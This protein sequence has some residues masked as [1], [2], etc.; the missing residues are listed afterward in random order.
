LPRGPRM[1]SYISS[2][3]S[4]LAA[5][6][7]IALVEVSYATV[8]TSSAV[9]RSSF[10][11]WN[12]N[13]IELFQKAL[14]YE[15]LQNA[16]Q[17]KPAVIQIGD[18]SGLHAIV[19]RIVDQYLEGLKYENV[20]C[21]ANT[22]FD[23]YYTIAEFMLRNSPSIKAVVLYLSWQNAPRDPARMPTDMIG[24]GD[25]MRNALGWLAPFVSPPT[26]SARAEIL[27]SVYTLSHVIEQPSLL[28]FDVYP[29][30]APLVEFLRTS[31]GWW[32]EHDTRASPDKRQRMLDSLCGGALALYDS[33]QNYT[34]D[35]FGSR[36][37]YT[38]VE[39]RR[40]AN[41]TAQYN[42]KLVVIFQP[43]PCPAMGQSYLAARQVD[44]AAVVADHPNVVIPDPA[45]FE[46]WPGEWFTSADHLRTGHEDAASRRV[47]RAV[48]KALNLPDREPPSPPVAKAPV[49]S[50]SSSDF[51][52]PPWQPIGLVLK[53]LQ[54]AGGGFL[55][56]E[57]SAAGLHR[58]EARLPDLPARTYAFSLMFRPEGPRQLRFELMDFP[59]SKAFGL[60]RCDPTDLEASHS[61]VILDSAIEELPGGVFRCWG[62]LK[63]AKDGA[64]VGIGLSHTGRDLGPYQGDGS[65]GIIL[66]SVEIS[67]IDDN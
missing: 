21:C 28:P 35:A 51:G 61:V 16:V 45:L 25:H 49:L 11:N 2:F 6:A 67:A 8:D 30:F 5:L 14:I 1:N 58:L 29:P 24:G 9:E 32:P 44:V 10:L 40:L 63:L 60:V 57:T 23:G 18:S 46:A 52:A 50:W 59:S 31:A 47:G 19:P 36:Q 64:A 66:Y 3:R 62:K 37:S 27:R 7:V 13:S 39:L 20:S 34:R 15:K 42:A 55:A 53:R 17:A 26:L 56:T 41:L 38:Q 12:F 54:A 33:A 48:A 65:S 43:Y 4:L 22:G